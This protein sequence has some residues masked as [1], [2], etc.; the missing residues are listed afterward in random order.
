M[1]VLV[2]TLEAKVRPDLRNSTTREFRLNGHVPAVVYGKKLE[3]KPIAVD[4]I[5]FVKLVREVGR[6]GIISLTVD[7]DNK[8][9]QVIVTD[10][11]Q[12]PIKGELVHIDFFEVDMT[13]KMDANVPVRL[14]GEA[15][16][17]AEGGMVSH[18]LHEI[19]VRALPNE[20]PE[21]IEVDISKLMIGDSVL[22]KE[23]SQSVEIN[24][25]EEETIVTILHAPAEQEP[26]QNPEPDDDEGGHA[27]AEDVQGKEE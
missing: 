23:L 12:D 10:I 13:S 17:V 26:G 27:P 15:P 21:S 4:S 16:G 19:S 25:D 24:N 18:L 6:N 9:H 11:Q 7:G 8:S 1:I 2:A 14:V 22:V 5:S 3:S 20:I